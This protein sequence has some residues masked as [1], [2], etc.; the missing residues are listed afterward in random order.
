MN[1]LNELMY[2]E[3]STTAGASPEYVISRTRLTSPAYDG[4]IA[5]LLASLGDDGARYWKENGAKGIVVLRATVM[6]PFAAS[7]HPD[8]MAGLAAALKKAAA[9]SLKK[10]RV[11][12]DR[13]E[14]ILAPV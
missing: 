9:H 3:M 1:A 2:Q 13:T 4:A 8:H 14:R 6:N 5:P 12:A 11:V 7:L 10:L